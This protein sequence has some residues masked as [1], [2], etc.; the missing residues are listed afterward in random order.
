M[1]AWVMCV[2]SF[3]TVVCISVTCMPTLFPSPE[4]LI[5]VCVKKSWKMV[6]NKWNLFRQTEVVSS[7]EYL[8][9]PYCSLLW[10]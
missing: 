9:K 4:L 1:H 5:I 8:V 3:E 2:C 7:D 10:R 6:R